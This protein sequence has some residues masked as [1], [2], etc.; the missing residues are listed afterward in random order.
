[1]PRDNDG[2]K[3][4]RHG[5]PWNELE[6]KFVLEQVGKKVQIYKIAEDVKRTSTGVYSHLKEIAVKYIGSGMTLEEASDATSVTIPD[7]QDYIIRKDLASKAKIEK[8]LIQS[9][10]NF[11]I[12]KEETLLS[13]AIEIRDLLKKLVD[14]K[15]D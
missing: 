1:M 6:E 4:E 3:P 7:I 14:A 9:T 8:G 10:L 2:T 5:K 11:P 15:L 13:V 12:Q